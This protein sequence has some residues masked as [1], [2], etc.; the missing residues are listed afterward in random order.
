MAKQIESL[1]YAVD[2]DP[3]LAIGTDQ[4]LVES[5][6]KSILTNEKFRSPRPMT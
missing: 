5:C 1:E 4:E 6:C 3:E 2:S